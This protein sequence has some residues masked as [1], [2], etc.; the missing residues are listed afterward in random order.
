MRVF[1]RCFPLLILAL[2]FAG[3]ALSQEAAE[4]GSGTASVDAWVDG[5]VGP[6]LGEVPGVPVGVIS[7]KAGTAS[8]GSKAASPEKR[9]LALSCRTN[10]SKRSSFRWS[11]SMSCG[12]TI[13]SAAD[14]GT[15]GLFS[16]AFILVSSCW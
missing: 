13:A 14:G 11:E 7:S 8:R 10:S 9:G 16:I 6:A 3:P 5:I 4:E 15:A 1:G 2:T 12:P